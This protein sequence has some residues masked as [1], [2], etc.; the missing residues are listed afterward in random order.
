[1]TDPLSLIAL[2]A[3]LGGISGKFSEKAWELA[4]KWL[5]RRYEDHVV[6][7]WGRATTSC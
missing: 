2:G 5:A 4:E 1:M 3:A 6:I 7:L